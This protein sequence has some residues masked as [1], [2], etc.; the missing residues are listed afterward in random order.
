[1]LPS[2]RNVA[3]KDSSFFIKGNTSLPSPADVR[4][5][6]SPETNPIRPLPVTLP[7]LGLVVK[8]GSAITLAEGQCLWAIRRL[9]PSVPVPEVYGWCQDNDQTFIYMQMING[10]PL[11][12]GWPELDIEEKFEISMQLRRIINDLRKLRQACLIRARVLRIPQAPI[13]NAAI[14]TYITIYEDHTST[15]HSGTN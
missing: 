10:S 1:M 4:R 2:N 11:A 14:C 3:F 15:T 13:I 5:A 7:S 6:A 8:Y 12:Q 9:L